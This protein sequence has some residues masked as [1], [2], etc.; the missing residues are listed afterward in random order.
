MSLTDHLPIKATSH[1]TAIKGTG[2]A[3]YNLETQL[4]RAAV[5]GS[6]PLHALKP[7]IGTIV[8]VFNQSFVKKAIRQ[9]GLSLG[10]QILLTRHILKANPELKASV[11][12]K[13]LVKKVVQHFGKE[14]TSKEKTHHFFRPALEPI[15]TKH[16]AS[17]NQVMHPTETT[18]AFN[19]TEQ[20][21]STVVKNKNYG[22]IG[23]LMDSKKFGPT[24]LPKKGFTPPHLAV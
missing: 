19:K 21:Q 2:P 17:I 9:G 11:L 12:K 20:R 13:N 22:G 18:A 7:H 24:T 15:D 10:E 1:F 5:S 6:S 14:M 8:G 3:A 4:H 16:A 23:N